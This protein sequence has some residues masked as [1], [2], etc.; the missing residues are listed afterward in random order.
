[1]S[2]FLPNSSSSKKV[3]LVSGTVIIKLAVEMSRFSV[4]TRVN[5]RPGFVIASSRMLLIGRVVSAKVLNSGI[6]AGLKSIVKC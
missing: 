3:I 6:N 4:S 1:M 5:D 2:I